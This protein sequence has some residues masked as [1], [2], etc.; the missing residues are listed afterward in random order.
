MLS[1]LTIAAQ[2]A[3]AMKNPAVSYPHRRSWRSILLAVLTS[4]SMLLAHS[5]WRAYEAARDEAFRSE[6]HA[7]GQITVPIGIAAL[8]LNG[9]SWQAALKV[10]DEALYAAKHGGRNQVAA[11]PPSRV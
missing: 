8:P 5:S 6:G 2:R 9:N 3:L 7:F 4:V 11:P 10:A 1:A